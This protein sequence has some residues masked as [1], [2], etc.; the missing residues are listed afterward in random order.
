MTW[1]IKY[2]N[3]STVSVNVNSLLREINKQ[4]FDVKEKLD[5]IKIFSISLERN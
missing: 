5:D 4:Q 1:K 2:K 3:I